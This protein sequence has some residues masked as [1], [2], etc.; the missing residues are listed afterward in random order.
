MLDQ[1]DPPDAQYLAVITLDQPFGISLIACTEQ[2][3]ELPA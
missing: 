1:P 3:L 2:I